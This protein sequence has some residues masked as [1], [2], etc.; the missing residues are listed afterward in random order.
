[1]IRLTSA[2][3]AAGAMAGRP[4]PTIALSDEIEL[5][6]WRATDAPAVIE[7]FSDAEIQRWHCRRCETTAEAIAWIDAELRAWKDESSAS[8]AIADVDSQR[9]LGRVALHPSLGDGWAE[10]SYWVLPDARGRGLATAAAAVATRWAHELGIHRVQLEHSIHNERSGRVAVKAGFREEGIRRG[11]GLHL[12][13]W[14]DMRH[15]S[16]LSTDE[17]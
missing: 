14:H 7:A 2:V 13:G 8:W 3:V 12:D 6:P 5:R 11:G 9:V 16:H 17:H 15:Y 4:Q 1:M 10:V